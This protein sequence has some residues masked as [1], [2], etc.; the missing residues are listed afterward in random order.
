[1][2]SLS[3]MLPYESAGIYEQPKQKF[4]FKVPRVVSDQKAKFEQDDWFKKVTRASEGR[5]TGHRE[6]P[7]EERRAKFQSDLKTNGRTE[8]ALTQN[9]LNLILEFDISPNGYTARAPDVDFAK[10][11]GMVHLTSKSIILNGVCVR[12]KGAINLESLSGTGAI[13]FDDE[14]AQEEDN[15]L[16][17][18]LEYY[19]QRLRDFND[20][21]KLYKRETD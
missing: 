18:Q 17:Q 9:G 11:P 14:M 15:R 13:E 8:L 20:R 4:T 1:M 6:R 2:A 21:Q 19:N 10:E 12:W 3:A 7:M 16:R 5:Y